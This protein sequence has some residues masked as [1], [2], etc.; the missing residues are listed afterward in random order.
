MKLIS[1]RTNQRVWVGL[2]AAISCAWAPVETVVRV[3]SGILAPVADWNS[4]N[5]EIAGVFS[6]CV[7][8]GIRAIPKCPPEGGRYINQN[9]IRVAGQLT[10]A[11]ARASLCGRRRSRL[12]RRRRGRTRARRCRSDDSLRPIGPQPDRPA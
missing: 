3:V 6:A 11:R 9:Q 2:D 10:S 4:W 7:Q 1:T 12:L 5:E 8:A